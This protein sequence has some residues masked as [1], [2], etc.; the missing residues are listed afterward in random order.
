MNR[1]FFQILFLS[2]VL[3]GCSSSAIPKTG[4]SQVAKLKN[5]NSGIV[6]LHTE[7]TGN[8]RGQ[9]MVTLAKPNARGRYE[10][11]RGHLIKSSSD[12][13]Q[14]P[15]QITLAAG[16]YGI[17]ELSIADEL[18]GVIRTH[19][20]RSYKARNMTLEGPLLMKVYERPMATFTI[21]AGEVVDIGS[22]QVFE[23]P[24]QQS[25]FG[26]KGSFAIKVAPTPEAVLK[27]L[28][29]RSPAL[30]NARVVRTMTATPQTE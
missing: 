7:F 1:L 8:S 14:L 13:A 2:A 11:T 22:I 6:L 18:D 19:R 3:Q 9:V 17:V 16:Q 25:I 29:E 15:G 4:E 30:A 26:Q 21:N 10:V 23:G 5:D 20:S 24:V 28:A 12:S 27:N